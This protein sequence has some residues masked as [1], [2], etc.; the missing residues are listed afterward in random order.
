MIAGDAIAGSTV[1]GLTFPAWVPAS[2]VATDERLEA[3]LASI[4]IP[5]MAEEATALFATIFVFP[6]TANQR[7]AA[8][9]AAVLGYAVTAQ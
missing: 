3:I 9:L 5:S 4:F 1:D 7:A 2:A 6:V 8:A